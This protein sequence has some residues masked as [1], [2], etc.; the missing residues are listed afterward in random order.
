MSNTMRATPTKGDFN[1]NRRECSYGEVGQKSPWSRTLPEIVT[2]DGRLLD[3]DDERFL[4]NI[5]REVDRSL[6]RLVKDAPIPRHMINFRD[7]NGLVGERLF[8]FTLLSPSL[9]AS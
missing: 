8:V 5:C 1:G 6:L 3:P 7:S 4:M 2:R 9:R